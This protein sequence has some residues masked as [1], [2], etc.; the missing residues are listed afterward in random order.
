MADSKLPENSLHNKFERL[1]VLSVA[2]LIF[3]D[4]YKSR[5]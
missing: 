5:K 4:E 3:R 2:S 1:Y